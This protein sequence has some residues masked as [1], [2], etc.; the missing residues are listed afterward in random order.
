[1][2]PRNRRASPDVAI[3]A[4]ARHG[5]DMSAHRSRHAGAGVLEAADLVVVFDEI[6]LRSIKKRYPALRNRVF[7]LGELDAG[8]AEIHDPEG[9]TEATF[10]ATY[11]RIDACLTA[12][13][14]T[15]TPRNA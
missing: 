15:L 1:M 5:V 4:A 7:L 12:L 2:L 13:A 9:K 11:Q 6:N 8:Q 3:G 14:Q 10:L